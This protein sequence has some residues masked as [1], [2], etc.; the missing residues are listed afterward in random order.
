MTNAP[1]GGARSDGSPRERHVD[2]RGNARMVDVGGKQPER[3]RATARALVRL[4]AQAHATLASGALAKGDAL[5]VARIAAIQAAKRTADIIPLC[6]PLP[7][8]HLGVEIDLEHAPCTVAITVEA[9][10]T[11]RTGVEMEAL[12]GASAGALALYDMTKGEPGE[13][14]VIESVLLLE[15]VVE[16]R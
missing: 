1:T 14:P 6:H 12:T 15:K 11:S 9:R 8:D 5:A 10:T 2:S 4:N 16:G 3:R 7:L 13:P